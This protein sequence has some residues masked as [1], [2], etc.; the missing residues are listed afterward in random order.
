[1]KKRDMA[2]IAFVSAILWIAIATLAYPAKPH[3]T[4]GGNSISI[5]SIGFNRFLIPWMLAAVSMILI[6]VFAPAKGRLPWIAITAIV[7]TAAVILPLNEAKNN[8]KWVTAYAMANT[9]RMEMAL[10]SADQARFPEGTTEQ[11]M[12]QL[13]ESGLLRLPEDMFNSKGCVVDPWGTPYKIE[14]PDTRINPTIISAGRNG[15]FEAP[16]DQRSDDVVNRR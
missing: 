2:T 12:A 11:I 1:M 16:N 15:E 7:A 9:I 3:I 4:G 13:R 14:F 10:F 6:W 8:S 5:E